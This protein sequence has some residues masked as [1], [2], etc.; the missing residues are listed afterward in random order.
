MLVEDK[1]MLQQKLEQQM[2]QQ[3]EN[4][5]NTCRASSLS[6]KPIRSL[7]VQLAGANENLELHQKLKEKLKHSKTQKLQDM[8]TLNHTRE[9]LI[10]CMRKG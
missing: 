9:G 5:L 7:E 10:G 8:T 6:M 4:K 1:R 3:R 2:L